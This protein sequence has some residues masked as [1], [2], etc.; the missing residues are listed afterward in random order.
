MRVEKY[1]EKHP[2]SL[3]DK[4]VLFIG[5][6][7]SI[8]FEAIKI[9]AS[10]GA[11]LYLASRNLKK[12]EKMIESLKEIYPDCVIESF[13]LDVSSL[14]NIDEFIDVIE[15][16]DLHFDYF[17]NNAG[18]YHMPMVD[19]SEGYDL[20]FATNTLG[21]IY[22]L[23]KMIPTL[24]VGAKVVSTSSMSYKFYKNDLGNIALR[25][26]KNKMKRYALSKQELVNSFMYL[27][28]NLSR[29]DIEMNLVH[30][31]IVPTEL[32]EKSHGKFFMTFVFPIMKVLF[33]S[34]RKASL[35]LIHAM[36]TTTKNDEWIGPRG[37]I[38]AW[39]TPKI[40]RLKKS[41]LRNNK[42]V[43]LSLNEMIEK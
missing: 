15:K 22:L 33:H 43:Y 17:I 19:T 40:L 27:K 7:G 2:L 12:A 31:G 29:K 5:W 20:T 18:V 38:E 8:G 1:L 30:P 41:V 21:H 11:K 10:Y 32:F 4:K 39:G 35:T 24:S 23:K 28:E 16:K 36:E 3:K 25:S 37:L 26:I 9:I 42:T 13:E 6:T 34:P 14:K